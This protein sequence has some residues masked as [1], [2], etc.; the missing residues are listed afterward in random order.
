MH[1][2]SIAIQ[3][4]E[5]AEEEALKVNSESITKL[6]L[7]IGTLSGVVRDA[8]EF[9]MSEAIRGSKLENTQIVYHIIEAVAVCEDC[10]NEFITDDYFKICPYC[11]SMNTS[12]LKG[13]ELNIKSIE[14]MKP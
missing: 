9:A 4:V 11:G 1:E 12:F 14:V 8:L 7:E 6:E 10:C 5:I 3:I 13:K 2:L